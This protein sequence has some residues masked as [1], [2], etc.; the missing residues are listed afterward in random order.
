MSFVVA[1]A[2]YPIDAIGDWDDYARKLGYWIDEAAR[3]GADLAMFPEYAAMEL[4]AADVGTRGDLSGSLRYVASL[5]PRV[6]ELHADLSRK[7]GLYILAAS[8]PVQCDDGRIVNRSRLFSPSGR[9][10]WQDKCMMTRFER[11]TWGVSGGEELTL[12]ETGLGRIGVLICYDAEFPELAR[13]LC[14]AGADI[15]LVPSCTD[16]LQGY[17]RVRLA[18]QARALENQLHVVQ[19]VTVGHAPWSPAVD[20]NRGAASIFAPPDGELPDD[21]VCAIGTLDD[22]NWVFGRIDIR[23]TDRLRREGAVL[24]LRDQRELETRRPLKAV[25]WA[26]T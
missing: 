18:C 22:P 26:L 21:G 24:N 12:F 6:D 25:T 17:W 11:E 7:T 20:I 8:T 4:A 9:I 3:G 13:R 1:S 16:T 2:Q 23:L 14:E 15:L 10:G 19:S 5:T